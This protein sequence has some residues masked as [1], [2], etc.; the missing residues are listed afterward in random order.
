MDRAGHWR[1]QWLP[2]VATHRQ[3]WIPEH[4]KGPG[5]KPLVLKSGVIDFKR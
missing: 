3:Q 2:S 5:D 1:N 4:I